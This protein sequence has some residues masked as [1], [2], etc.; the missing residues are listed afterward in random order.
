MIQPKVTTLLKAT[1]RRDTQALPH[2]GLWMGQYE[3]LRRLWY[4]DLYNGAAAIRV[5]S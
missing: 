1:P 5:D 2:K 3:I 4:V